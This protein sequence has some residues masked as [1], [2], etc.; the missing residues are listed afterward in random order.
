MSELRV[1]QVRTLLPDVDEL[2][3]LLDRMLG[4]SVS[5]PS[6]RWSA[7]GELETVGSRLVRTSELDEGLPEVLERERARLAALYRGV[8]RALR[9]LEEGDGALA[10]AVFLELAEL[11]ERSWRMDRAE[12]WALAAW[13]VARDLRD[14]RPAA[15]AL[16]RAA[17]SA[18][19]R[20]HLTEAASRYQEALE[21]AWAAGDAR[22]SAVA[23][24]GCGNVAVDRGRWEEAGGW[25]VRALELV[26]GEASVPE[27]WHAFQ[28]L[29]IVAR[30][31]GDLEAS[32][33][34]L[35]RAEEVA[36]ALDDPDL[37]VEVEN[38]W[39]MWALAAGDPPAAEDRFRSALR[40]AEDPKAVVT[41]SVNLGHALLAQG[42]ILEAAE[43]AR[44]AE[45]E[46]LRAG[47]V[48]KLPEVYRLL[49]DVASAWGHEDDFVFYERALELTQAWALPAW[50]RLETLE[51]YAQLAERRG[52]GEEARARRQEADALRRTLLADT[53]EE[54]VS[55]SEGPS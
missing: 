46:A 7:S 32:R 31:R 6:R 41:V 42:R 26:A 28:N 12:A 15:L 50:E 51:G 49:G 33:R 52:R 16:R 48:I 22:G 53:N 24:V 38:G 3:P 20:G 2:R 21:M 44:G 43:A 40:S 19:S 23:A 27:R 8:S 13:R 5:D 25:Y 55:R 11:E 14:R 47:V 45:A 9:A 10:S 36:R 34:W 30:R 17:R 54:E 29:S 39:G 1:D 37:A 35:E 4:T 18:R